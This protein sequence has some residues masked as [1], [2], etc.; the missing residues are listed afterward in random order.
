[1]RWATGSSS[2]GG[3]QGC[4]PAV[5]LTPTEMSAPTGW[6]ALGYAVANPDGET[7]AAAGHRRNPPPLSASARSSC[8]AVPATMA[9]TGSWCARQLRDAGWRACACHWSATAV[10]LEGRCCGQRQSLGRMTAADIDDRRPHRR[11]AARRRARS[12]CDGEMATAHRRGQQERRSSR[13][14][15]RSIRRRRWRAARSAARRSTPISPS[16]SSAGSPAI[17]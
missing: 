12:R 9:A 17:C 8:C 10:A 6:R 15:R 5:L 3:W 1:M 2:S 11:R 13:R 14:D 7:P 4:R 16:R